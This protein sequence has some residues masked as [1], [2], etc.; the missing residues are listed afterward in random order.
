MPSTPPIPS[1]HEQV[2]T[3]DV[4]SLVFDISTFEKIVEE[5]AKD[6]MMEAQDGG[7][8]AL[9]PHDGDEV[10]VRPQV[11]ADERE[12]V[13]A[14]LEKHLTEP[15]TEDEISLLK[16]DNHQLFEGWTWREKLN[17]ENKRES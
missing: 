15:L 14:F 7:E 17:R 5:Y 2:P 1:R 13:Y 8:E 11:T 16:A 10:V 6:D 3:R 9:E 12:A 4:D